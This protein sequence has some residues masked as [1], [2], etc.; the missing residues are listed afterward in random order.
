MKKI[1]IS[2]SLALV[3]SANA[4]SSNDFGN[5][6]ICITDANGRTAVS[7]V[8]PTAMHLKDHLFKAYKGKH[9]KFKLTKNDS[10][11]HY[12][13]QYGK[14]EIRA[15]YIKTKAYD[16]RTCHIV[17]KLIID[18]KTYSKKHE[19]LFLGMDWAIPVNQ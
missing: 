3:I 19:I 8:T 10:F 4:M 18:G 17:N 13:K 12:F 11:E 9:H 16:G 7:R 15:Y 6:L 14:E 5:S 2:L 1:L